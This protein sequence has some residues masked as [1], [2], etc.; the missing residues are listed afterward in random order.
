ML[1]ETSEYDIAFRDFV[2]RTVN[3]LARARNA[4]LGEIREEHSSTVATVTE[5]R[6]GLRVDTDSSPVRF[7]ITSELDD[8]RAGRYE[9]LVIAL[10]EASG[11]L[12]D[13]LMGV[14][15]SGLDHVVQ[16]TGN[17]FN[18]SGKLTFEKMYEALDQIEWA[19][20]DEDELVE[21]QL[22]MH[23]DDVSTLPL[24]TP[25]QE[26][27]LREL[28]ARKRDELLARRRRRRLS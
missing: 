4:I 20:D 2:F 8:L 15:L 27:Q 12:E 23:P 7:A 26:R 18:V 11:Q 9:A 28:K 1:F 5:H 13:E 6:D 16:S 22:I 17:S 19:L 3:E 10:D 25:D 21:K 14:L 24:P